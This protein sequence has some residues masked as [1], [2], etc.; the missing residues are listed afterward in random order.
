MKAHRLRNRVLL[1]LTLAIAVLFGVFIFSF[2]RF[3]QK[4]MI[5]DVMS[6]LESLEDLFAAQLDSD[7]GMMGAGLGVILRDEQLQGCI[8]G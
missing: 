8:E 7:A 4:H 3:Q 2:Y 6:K 1:P 5:D